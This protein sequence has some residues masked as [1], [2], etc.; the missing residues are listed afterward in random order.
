MLVLTHKV[1]HSSD[2]KSLI[3][4]AT[5]SLNL[6]FLSTPAQTHFTLHHSFSQFPFIF[7]SV[8]A[9]KSN[10]PFLNASI[11]SLLFSST[12]TLLTSHV[13]LRFIHFRRKIKV[14]FTAITTF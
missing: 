1:Y 9:S 4:I 14:T 11:T 6:S 13:P 10:L 2:H 3:K 7:V 5:P 8:T 12:F